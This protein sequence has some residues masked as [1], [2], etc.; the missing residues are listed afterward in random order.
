MP[1][2]VPSI[3]LCLSILAVSFLT[4]IPAVA[5]ATRAADSAPSAEDTETT[6]SVA[7]GPWLALEPSTIPMPVGA[8]YGV[9]ELLAETMLPTGDLWTTPEAGEATAWPPGDSTTWTKRSAPVELTV[10]ADAAETRPAVA[11]LATYV[12][13][14]RFVE[15]ELVVE[16]AHLLRVFLDHPTNEVASKVASKTTSDP[17]PEAEVQTEAGTATA[18][19]ALFAGQHMVLVETIRDPASDAAWTVAA[20]LEVPTGFGGSI[21]PDLDPRR[22]VELEDFLDAERV[23]GI[24]LAP[25]GRHAALFYRAPGVPAEHVETWTDVVRIDESGESRVVRTLRGGE[26]DFSWR[27]TAAGG[28]GDV[29]EYV[30]GREGE[31]GTDLFLAALGSGEIRTLA[32][33]LEDLRD[34]RFFP[35]GESLLLVVAEPAEEDDRDVKRYRD[36]PDRWAGRRDRTRLVRL[37]LDGSRQRLSVGES[38][39]DVRDIRLDGAG[40]AGDGVVLVSRTRHGLVDRPFSETELVE[41]DLRTLDETTIDTL[42][43][44]DA[45]HYSPDGRT[46]LVLGSAALYDG[47]GRDPNLAPDAIAND[48]DTQAYLVD[49]TVG[50]GSP[51]RERPI[52]R[53]FDPTIRDATWSTHDGAIYFTVQDRSWLE[54]VR[55]DP[56]SDAFTE[57]PA[58]VDAVRGVDVAEAAGR[59]AYLGSSPGEPWAAY[60]RSSAVDAPGSPT[61]LARPA[62]ERFAEI[63]LPGAEEWSFTTD[64]GTEILGHVYYP[65]GFDPAAEKRWPMLVYYYGGTVPVDRSFGGRYPKELWASRGYVVYV[66]QPSGADGFGQEFS[67]RHVNAWGRRTAEEIV[68]GTERF[69]EAHPTVDPERVG[70]LGA[71]Y[72]GFMTLYLQT[73]TDRFAAAISHAGISNLASYWGQGWWGY[74]YSA[75]A[76]AES[77]PWNNPDLYVG[78]SPLYRADRITTPLLLLHGDADTNVPPVE[79][80]QMYTALKLLGKEVELIEIG[81]QDHTILFYPQRLL[82]SQTTL[83]WFDRWL[84]DQPEAWEYLWGTEDEPR[85]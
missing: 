17:A 35:D 31:T 54:I 51:G 20:R 76:S 40:N 57:L 71:S 5:D 15:A 81:G 47:L 58:G 59:I 23:Q 73:I 2:F 4:P 36:L 43:W 3:S 6:E 8:D 28:E 49:L 78:Q 26:G 22:R 44:F 21:E 9:A 7:L 25:D 14:D 84:K 65:P 72:G 27:P 34:V 11:W 63:E 69:L 52:T 85:G 75:A 42:G 55:Y 38:D 74:L 48:Y 79:S 80:H 33:G 67:A 32:R 77:Y 39:L 24:D 12:E 46:L 68:E 70:C 82:W 83:A 29:T 62:A 18:E 56:A 30:Y 64:D 19:I 13:V 60:V 50:P 41:I 61:T 66:P 1:R 37:F 45:A 53:D 10:P 16:G